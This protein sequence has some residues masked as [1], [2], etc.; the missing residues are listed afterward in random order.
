MQVWVYLFLSL[1]VPNCRCIR[2]ETQ[3]GPVWANQWWGHTKF[4]LCCMGK[5][6]LSLE[7]AWSPRVEAL[8]N[9]TFMWQPKW[10]QKTMSFVYKLVCSYT[11]A[12]PMLYLPVFG[13]SLG[14][15]AKFKH[16][17]QSRSSLLLWN[18]CWCYTVLWWSWLATVS[19]CA[20]S[21]LWT[22]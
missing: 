18:V 17:Q 3:G 7:H 16:L 21:H 13:C 15:G 5:I 12:M 10:R 22:L 11:S 9:R 4:M 6:P 1:L 2:Q 14:Q 19:I 8:L 20:K